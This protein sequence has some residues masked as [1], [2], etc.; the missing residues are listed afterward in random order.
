MVVLAVPNVIG[1]TGLLLAPATAPWLWAAATGLGMGSLAF[2]L[3]TISLRSKDN[4][5]N[6]SAV[7]QGV[8][9]VIAGFGVLACGW[10]HT[11]T[12]TWRAPLLLVLAILLGQIVSGHA[13]SLNSRQVVTPSLARK[14]LLGWAK[15]AAR[16][17]AAPSA[18]PAVQ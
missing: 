1:V 17:A 2:A 8:G 6:L 3:T 9:Y 16:S 5:P 7:V 15:T 13:Q 4:S 14:N 10:L 12:G 11:Q 18:E